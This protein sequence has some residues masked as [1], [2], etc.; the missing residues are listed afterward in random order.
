MRKWSKAIA[1]GLCVCMMGTTALAEANNEDV[2][3]S[4]TQKAQTQDQQM[5]SGMPGQQNQMTPPTMPGQ[6]NQDRQNQ[7]TPP[8]MPNQQSPD[9]QNSERPEM[10]GNMN[11][12]RPDLPDGQNSERPAMPGQQN[13]DGQNQMTPPAMPGQQNQ[14][15]QNSERPEMPGNMNGERP[16]L[17]DG[18]NGERPEMPGNMNGAPGMPGGMGG[19]GGDNAPTDYSAANT[20]TESTTGANYASNTDSEN[21]VLVS[22]GN[23][24][25][26]G[27]TVNKTG[28]SSNESADFYGIN[29]AVLATNGSTLTIEDAEITSDGGHANGVFSYGSGTTVNVSDT[30]ITTSGNNSGGLM[31]T[32]GATLNAANVTVATSGNSSAAIRSDR[33]GG[34]V[35]VTGG[36]YDTTGVGSP[37]IYSTADI[38]VSE[39]TLSA[40]TSEAVVIEGGNTVTLNNVEITGSNTKLNGQS[41]VKTNVLIYQSMSGDASEGASSFTMTDGSMTA[42]TG[43]MFHVTNTTTTINLENVD[44]TYASDSN[45]FLDASADSWGRTG[46]NGGQVTLNLKSQDITGAILSDSVSSVTLNLDA[47]STWTL[48]GD[49]YV[50]AFNGDLSHVNLNG[51]TLYVNGTAV[52]K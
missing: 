10:P 23:V 46:S 47:D 11:G 50:T 4:A 18:Q 48:T 22:Q 45:V 33:G 27:S 20:V 25:L 52:T 1:I 8:T 36:S 41:T 26:S 40:T 17:P 39:A 24:T 28:S 15:G 35:T 44:F 14:D 16:E 34:T 5:P 29:A 43:A 51:Y 38:T 12:E 21:A 49:S 37:A 2:V 32:G 31:T 13:Q 6:Q 3:S 42:E 9:G 19:P 7:M 30:S